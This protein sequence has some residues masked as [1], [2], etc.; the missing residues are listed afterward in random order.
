VDDGNYYFAAM[1]GAH[2]FQIGRKV[3]GVTTILAEEAMDLSPRVAYHLSLTSAAGELGASLSGG[4]NDFLELHASDASL[5][6]GRAALVTHLVRA[7]YDNVYVKPTSSTSLFSQEYPLWV[8]GRPLKYVGGNWQEVDAGL[9][10][11]DT[12][13]NAF[14]IIPNPAIDN[15]T[16]TA[17]AVLNSFGSTNPVAWFGVVARYTDPQNYYY[18]SIRSSNSLQIRKVVNGVDTVL[19]AV[20]FTVAPGEDHRY[21]FEV[22][23][24]ELSATVG[25]VVL[26]RAID[27]SLTS[28]QVGF[29]TYRADATY[30]VVSAEQP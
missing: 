14:A 5:V 8:F 12:S 9:R 27:N 20:T 7:D 19:K 26:A 21:E 24:T 23:G 15:Q 30:T 29:A 28:G 11:S 17:D 13:G 16:I 1:N 10:Q 25:G 4:A 3:N 22:R 18:L 6:H 2:T